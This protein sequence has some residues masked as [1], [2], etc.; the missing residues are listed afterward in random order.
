MKYSYVIIDGNVY[1]PT[2]AMIQ[3]THLDSI[4]DLHIED[5]IPCV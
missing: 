3:I 5:V 4:D 2:G 1:D